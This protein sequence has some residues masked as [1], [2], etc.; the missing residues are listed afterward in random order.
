MGPSADAAPLT[1]HV[2]GRLSQRTVL[3][4]ASF[5]AFLA[6]LDATIVNVAFPSI[7]ESFPDSTISSLSWIL[8]AYSIVFAAFLVVSGR[9]ADLLGRR[10]AFTSGVAIFTA[11]SVAC[12]LSGSVA[13]PRRRAHGPGVRR[14]DARA[15]VAR[16]RGRGV[17]GRTPVA[18]GRPLGSLRRARLGARPADRR[19]ARR[20]RR[21][22]VGLPRQ[23]AVRPR[24]DVGRT[25]AARGEPR[26]RPASPPRPRRR[27]A[28]GG[29]AR[30]AHPRHRQ[31]RGLGLDEPRGARV[32][33]RVGPAPRRLPAQLATPPRPAAG[34][35]AAAHP[36]LRRRQHRDARRRDGLLRLPAHEHPV[37]AVRVG[38]LR[39]GRR[40]RGRAG[41]ARRGRARRSPR[42]G[43]RTTRVPHRDHPRRDR[44]GPRLRLVRRRG[45]PHP[46][47]PR[48]V[49]AGP[50]PQRR[51]G[52][53][54]APRPRQRGAGGRAGR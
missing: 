25:P 27:G 40:P 22:A 48:R 13:H 5:G 14:G 31:G 37:A 10:R 2:R 52:R 44:V 16:P 46:R 47:L 54:H 43:C 17:P 1:T 28:L 23:P 53:G 12:A 6:F 39:A 45:R 24:R 18:R 49:A 3:L 32:L 42:P 8:N 29:H 35:G 36:V 15:R 33:R 26:A 30:H 21:L 41:R 51:R 38:L 19:C 4:V 7:R 9:L 20:D 50:A 11:A 34:P